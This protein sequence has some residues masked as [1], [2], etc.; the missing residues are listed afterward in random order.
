MLK[1]EKFCVFCGRPP[2]NKN[3]EHVVPQWLIKMTGNPNRIAAFG[4]DFM[5]KPFLP[6]LFSFDSL[7][8]PACSNCNEA[9]S[10]LETAT[11]PVVRKLLSDQAVNEDEFITLL[12][13]L[14]KVRV[15]LWLGYLYLDKN[16][17]GIKPSFHIETRL[18]R[19]D[20]AVTI[21][22]I[23]EAKTAL[24]FIGPESRFYQLTPTFLALR[25][26]GLC[27]VNA[28]GVSLCGQRL[29]FPFAEPIGVRAD[30]KLEVSLNFGSGR[31]MHPVERAPELPNVV[32]I[33][34]PVFR[35][36]VDSDDGKEFL[37]NDWVRKH[38]ADFAKGYGKLFLQDADSVRLYP[39]GDSSAWIP[40]QSWKIWE[41]LSRVSEYIF[42]R[43]C[44]AFEA[45]IGI[46]SSAEQRK[47]MRR[48]AVMVKTMDRAILQKIREQA[49]HIRG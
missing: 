41:V 20:R 24:T 31:V 17:F 25:I 3:K 23:E 36:F 18:G 49:A 2:Q 27:L 5:K 32:S 11:E 7:A 34:Q 21:I 12:D 33:Y 39:E 19:L 38:T 30:H 10:K 48:Q 26:N 4:V 16:P 42:S 8:F 44:H 37:E 35:T 9:F 29:G 28:S 43:L 40:S 1:M 13:W 14:D 6:R 15:G 47:H 45:G 46:T 22:K